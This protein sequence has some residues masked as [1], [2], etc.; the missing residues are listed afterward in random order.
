MRHPSF[1]K[2]SL[3]GRSRN[4]TRARGQG[5]GGPCIY[6][7]DYDKAF[8]EVAY[9]RLLRKMK[10]YGIS[11]HTLNWT[12]DFPRKLAQIVAVNYE[13]QSD[14]GRVTVRC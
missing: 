2:I 9:K 8:D 11:G 5:A 12:R 1:G 14:W 10:G 4:Y 13:Q 3:D 6:V 7:Y